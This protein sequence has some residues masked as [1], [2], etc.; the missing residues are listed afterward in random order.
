MSDTFAVLVR[1]QSGRV[2][3]PM[4]NKKWKLKTFLLNMKV[5]A[6]GADVSSIG[7]EEIIYSGEQYGERTLESLGFLPQKQITVYSILDSSNF[8]VH[9]KD[10]SGRIHQLT[11]NIGWT[12]R[13]LLENIA[14]SLGGDPSS[15]GVNEC[16]YSREKYGERILG[17]FGIVPNKQITAYLSLN[18]LPVMSV[19]RPM[20]DTFV[21]IVRDSNGIVHRPIVNKKWKF[22]TF[23]QSMRV[24]AGGADVMSIG[25]NECTYSEDKYGERTLESLGFAPNKQIVAY[26][27][28]NGGENRF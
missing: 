16:I 17:F 8:V 13:K 19:V 23:L 3:Q 6:E 9:V 27:T 25:V 11:V 24:I 18:L 20:S 1:Y 5:A 4:V 7:V 21:V 2:I 14:A 26:A 22:K 15:I 28:L 10:Q 12:L